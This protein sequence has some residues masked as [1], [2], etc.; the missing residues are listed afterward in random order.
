[1]REERNVN[2][3]GQFVSVSR[4]LRIS[5]LLANYGEEMD[6]VWPAV[7]IFA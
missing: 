1:M 7:V 4:Y 3:T 5:S 6:K 2:I